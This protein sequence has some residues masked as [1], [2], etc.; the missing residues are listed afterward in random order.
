MHPHGE[1]LTGIAADQD[2]ARVEPILIHLGGVDL[3][4]D[5][6]LLGAADDGRGD[7]QPGS[8][9]LNLGIDQFADRGAERDFL[10]HHFRDG[11]GAGDFGF[12]QL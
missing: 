10:A 11:A 12:G 7:A 8:I 4:G 6:H 2:I 9:A 1:A 5:L 3:E